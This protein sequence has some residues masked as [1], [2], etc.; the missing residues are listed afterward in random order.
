[1]PN[2]IIIIEPNLCLLIDYIQ[3]LFKI[4]YTDLDI[5]TKPSGSIPCDYC[6]TNLQIG[7]TIIRVTDGQEP[8][9]Q[10]SIN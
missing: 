5:S 7:E 1:M 6:P 3:H 4:N 9:H 10:L 8:E 2:I